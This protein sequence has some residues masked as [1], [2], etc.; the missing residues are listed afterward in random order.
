MSDI[1]K[2]RV[3]SSLE[4]VYDEDKITQAEF[5]AMTMLKDEKKSFQIAVET[6]GE[7]EAEVNVN[8]ALKG[9]SLYT[10][11]HIKSKLPMWKKDIDDYY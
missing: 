2:I 7:Y 3:I 8:S 6:N 4:K 10:V 11:K 9:I 1:I 5:S